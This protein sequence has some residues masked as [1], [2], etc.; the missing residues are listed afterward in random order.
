MLIDSHYSFADRDELRGHSGEPRCLEPPLQ[1]PVLRPPDARPPCVG[2]SVP[3][4]RFSTFLIRGLL[5]F[6]P[7]SRGLGWCPCNG[8]GGGKVL[9]PKQA[10]SKLAG[11]LLTSVDLSVNLHMRG[12]KPA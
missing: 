2:L 8:S 11:G 7:G 5:R 3:E 6:A 1:A 10:E 12:K 4:H 9:C